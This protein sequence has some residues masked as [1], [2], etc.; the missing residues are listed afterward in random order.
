MLGRW[1]DRSAAT[2]RVLLLLLG[3]CACSTSVL[4]M[5]ASQLDPILLA[6]YRLVVATLVLL[7]LLLR[8]LRVHRERFGIPELRRTLLPGLVLGLHF[9]SWIIGARLTPAVNSTAIVNM[10]PVVTPFLLFAIA[11][12]SLNRSE[13]TGTFLTVLGILLLAGA[14]LQFNRL[15][16]R[17]DAI[18]LLSMVLFA[19][20]LVMGR[21]N[22]DFPSLWLYL[23][24]LYAVA[25]TLCLAISLI[26]VGPLEQ[27]YSLRE[28]WLILGL[29]L[30]PTVLGHSILNDAMKHF[31]GQVVS[32]MNLSQA[33]FAGVLAFF[34]LG[35]VP[36]LVFYP[37]CAL[38]ALGALLA[39]RGES[40][41]SRPDSSDS[42]EQAA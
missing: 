13:W 5:K 18:C 21:R 23:V 25:A 31:R 30:V 22:R 2:A 24:P 20:Y 17:G 32:T 3:A 34:F 4:F 38:M 41:P 9:I 7:P 12:E 19:L 36:D 10:V 14:D 39:L 8:D 1:P 35:E 37:A 28:L 16:F 11:H 27:S 26:R 40:E 42:A 15:Y 6:C 33:I 29:G